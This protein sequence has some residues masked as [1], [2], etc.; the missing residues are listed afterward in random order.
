LHNRWDDPAYAAIKASLL[1]TF[2]QA[3][4][5]KEPTRMARIAHA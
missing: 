3:E 5:Q 4:I 2:V 1:L